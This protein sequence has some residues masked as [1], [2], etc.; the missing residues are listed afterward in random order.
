[1]ELAEKAGARIA[2]HG[3]ERGLWEANNAGSGGERGRLVLIANPDLVLED[4]QSRRCWPQ[5][6]ALSGGG[7]V[8]APH[9]GRRRSLLLPVALAALA[10][11]PNPAGN[12]CV[13]EGDCRAPFLSGACLLVRREVFLALGGFDPAIFLFYE[14]DDLCR[15]VSDAGHALVHVHAAVARHGRGKLHRAG[16]G[17]VFRSRWHQAWSRAYVS[18]KY[19]LPAR[20]PAMLALNAGRTL[21]RAAQVSGAP[22]IERYAGSAAGALAFRGRG[23]RGRTSQPSPSFRGR[24]AEP[25]THRRYGSGSAIAGRDDPAACI[26]SGLSLREPEN[27][28]RDQYRIFARGS[29]SV[30]IR[31]RT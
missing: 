7:P 16:A 23:S 18:R 4:A 13:P 1:M 15:R 20:R 10:F 17:R 30:R 24:A 14:D 22:L 3:T 8:R 29:P 21:A 9:P 26:G 28:A 2:P 25:G 12:P 19:G 31:S 6:E 11:L 5:P 27:D